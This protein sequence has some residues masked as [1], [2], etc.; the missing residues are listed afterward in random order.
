[1]L[2]GSLLVRYNEVGAEAN[3]NGASLALWPDSLLRRI[4]LDH[5]PPINTA[6]AITTEWTVVNRDLTAL[7]NGK[8]EHLGTLP[9]VRENALEHPSFT[10]EFPEHLP[11][12]KWQYCVDQLKNTGAEL[13]LEVAFTA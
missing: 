2:I 10:I 1:V 6:G 7:V 4:Y 13:E 9:I 8:T 12:T 11:Q 3:K 5:P